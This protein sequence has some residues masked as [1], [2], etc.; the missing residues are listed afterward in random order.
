MKKMLLY[1]F[2]L[3]LAVSGF[4]GCTPQESG[5]TD[6]ADTQGASGTPS[7]NAFAAGNAFPKRARAF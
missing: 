4:V 3:L 2:A 1:A 5:Q 6:P 7:G